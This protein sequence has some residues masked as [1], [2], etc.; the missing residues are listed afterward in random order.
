MRCNGKSIKIFEK[1]I[2]CHKK[3]VILDFRLTKNKKS[4]EKNQRFFGKKS[5]LVYF[6]YKHVF[7]KCQEND[8][9]LHE[10]VN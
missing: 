3:T 1:S 7:L 5:V 8:A 9:D 6:L 10:E 2:K 4:K